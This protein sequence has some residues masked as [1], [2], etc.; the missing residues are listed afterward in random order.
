[1]AT[2]LIIDPQNDFHGGGS[3]AVPGADEDA[4]RTNQF[5]LANLDNITRIV[6]T[7]DS[8]HKI[9]I[10]HGGFWTAGDDSTRRPA[11]FTLISKEDVEKR[12]WVP[13]LGEHEEHCRWYLESLESKGRFKHIIWPE[14]CLIGTTG[15]AVKASI[16]EAAHIWCDKH[17]KQVEWVIKGENPLTEMYS[18]LAAEVPI[19]VDIKTCMNQ[20]LRNTLLPS[21]SNPESQLIVCGQAMSHCVNFTL[22]DICAGTQDNTETDIKKIAL[23]SDCA[24]PVAGFEGEADTFVADMKSLGVRVCTSLE[25]FQG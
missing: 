21:K 7:L 5:I 6:I 14:H 13:Q 3:L 18:A 12:V 22:R 9:D 20:N 4:M 2:L 17:N 24:S 11:P 19:D 1:M 8:H 10:G 16:M 23:L 15:H 25:V